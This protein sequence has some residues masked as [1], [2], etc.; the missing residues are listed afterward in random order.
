MVSAKGFEAE[1]FAWRLCRILFFEFFE[2][3]Y[4]KVC[5]ES[6]FEPATQQSGWQ[7]QWKLLQWAMQI[8]C[9][10]ETTHDWAGKRVDFLMWNHIIIGWIW[11]NHSVF[12]AGYLQHLDRSGSVSSW[13]WGRAPQSETCIEKGSFLIWSISFSEKWINSSN[14]F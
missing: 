9:K 2:F 12:Y 4:R 6:S 10:S 3:H 11:M 7:N 5:F 14:L 8:H 1:W 13:G